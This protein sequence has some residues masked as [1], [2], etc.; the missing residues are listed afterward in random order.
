M[1]VLKKNVEIEGINL[2]KFKKLRNLM[3]TLYGAQGIDKNL[4]EECRIK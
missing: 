3:M 2:I 4:F 1:R